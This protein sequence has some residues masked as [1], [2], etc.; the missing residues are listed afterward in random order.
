MLG[1][2]S[3]DSFL[4]VGGGRSVLRLCFP[5]VVVEW[6]DRTVDVSVHEWLFALGAGDLF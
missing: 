5:A 4:V 3:V 1:V 2:T 6:V